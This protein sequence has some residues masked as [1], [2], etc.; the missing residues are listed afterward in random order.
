MT[1]DQKLHQL[2]QNWL[3]QDFDPTT[4]AELTELL[5]RAKT[6]AAAQIDL[7]DRFSGPLKFGTAGLRAQVGAGESRMN[8]ATVAKAAWGVAN[9]MLQQGL[10]VLVVGNDARHG[11]IEFAEDTCAIAAALNL[12]VIRLQNPTP[13]PVLAYAL[14]KFGADAAIM[15]TASHNPAQDNGYK[16]YDK[17]G[18][19]IISPTDLEI[20]KLIAAAPA[21]NQI[22]RTGDYETVE[23][24][25][26]YVAAV[27]SHAVKE[28][29]T[30]LKI[31]Y[32][33]LHGVGSITF[34]KLMQTLGYK[35]VI[36]VAAQQDP[37]RNFPTVKFPN[38]E[39]PGAMDL[40]L[41]LAA[42]QQA[43]IVIA[44][45]PDADRTAVAIPTATSW[46]VL[47]GDELGTLLA[48]WSIQRLKLT[49]APIKG[50]MAASIVSSAMCSRIA[51][52]NGLDF[53]YTLTGFK[54]V[55]RVPNL[56][57]GYEEAIGY[58]VLP[59]QVK[60]KDGISAALF[61]IELVSYLKSQN[62]SALDQLDLLYQELGPVLTK[63]LTL[64]LP[65][66]TAVTEKLE[67]L[68]AN[69]P[70]QLGKTPLTKIENFADGI[71]SLPKA[72]GIKLSFAGGR[73][74]IRPSGT[75]PKLKCY[76]EVSNPPTG[77]LAAVKV[78]LQSQLAEL[79]AALT[80]LFEH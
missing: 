19:Q 44:N 41:Q 54:Y 26:D 35:N 65:T 61:A 78:A 28:L 42:N 18:S 11:S 53:S 75:E 47:S 52:A 1:L 36:E 37:D 43:D 30:D 45:D 60:D 49:G 21:A 71:D 9:W 66:T 76:I 6:D 23:I 40:V 27:A 8:R 79:V 70:T 22:S 5:D 51:A 50:A 69:L 33:A 3:A 77:D 80:E 46:Q 24:I 48:W 2:A 7:V 58:A 12:T 34:N 29:S 13:T 72:S 32:T 73:I 4:I 31:A 63:Q 57:F 68:L 67:Q 74:I 16:V 20:A 10:K 39:E 17:S 59:Q 14:T 55:S 56:I 64:R 15:V 38:P 62:L 25:D